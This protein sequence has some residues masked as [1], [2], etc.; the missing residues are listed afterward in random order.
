MSAIV[1]FDQVTTTT[2]YSFQIESI[3]VQLFTSARVRVNLLDVDGNRINVSFVTLAGE[4]YTNWGNSD[5]Y[6]LNFVATT[7]GFTLA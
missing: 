2:I 5:Q 7:L 3:D 6:I 1:P 4:D